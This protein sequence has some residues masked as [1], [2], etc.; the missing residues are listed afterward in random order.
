MKLLVSY[1]SKY[2]STAEIAEVIS[3]ELQK[4]EYEVEVKPVG[5]V[6]SLAGYDGFVIGSA[7]YAGGWLKPA[8]EFLYKNQD[9]LTDRPVWLFSSG[10]TGA[11]DPN[12]ILGGWTFPED[13]APVLETIKPRD[14]ILFHGKIDLDKLSFGEKMIIKSVKATV[15][16]Y[17]DWLVIRSWAS[18]IHLEPK[19]E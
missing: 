7:L 1:A 9:Q 16:D 14:V 17:R 19:T 2:G 5:E 11:G 12:E 6:D 8:A 10:P 15:G 18:L 3:K 4:R 13:L